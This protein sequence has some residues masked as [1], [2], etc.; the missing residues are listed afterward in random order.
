[1][2]SGPAA[3]DLGWARPERAT[4]TGVLVL[5]GSSGRL[6]LPRAQRLAAE[7]ATALALRWFGGVTP[8]SV[9]RQ[10]PVE[11]F[12]AA[13]DLLAE[14]CERL[15]ILGLSYGAEAALLTASHDPRVTGVIA[16]APTDVAWEGFGHDEDAP[17][18]SKWT[19][20]GADVPFVPL[21]RTWRPDGDPPS[22]VGQYRASWS[23][24]STEAR[25]AARIRV[26]RIA[27]EVLLVAGG[28]DAVWPAVEA[29][30]RIRRVR[31]RHGLATTLV[32]DDRAGH[33]VTFPGETPPDPRRPYRVGGDAGAAERLGRAAW[34]Q[35]LRLIGG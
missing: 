32:V 20:G 35:V 7:G 3:P 13:L 23:A 6:D 5:S 18:V 10:V 17:P 1:M 12:T 33:P 15:V 16:L 19:H 30:E 29:A 28:D 8:P 2:T 31:D 11:T 22:F 14:E 27:G 24:A 9:P 26:E 34:P 4:G 21:D 25:E